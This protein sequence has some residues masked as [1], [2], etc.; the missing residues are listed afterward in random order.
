MN[1]NTLRQLFT[2]QS[3]FDGLEDAVICHDIDL[4]ITNWNL[5]A[6]RMSATLLTKYL[7]QTCLSSCSLLFCL[8]KNA[9]I[10]EEKA[11]TMPLLMAS[12]SFSMPYLYLI[13]A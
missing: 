12:V 4:I 5:A 2:F 10:R 8:Q 9:D 1:T 13:I 3:I 11:L 7:T 6:E